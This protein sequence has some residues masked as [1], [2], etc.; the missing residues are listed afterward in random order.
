MNLFDTLDSDVQEIIQRYLFPVRFPKGQ[1]LM[2]EGDAGDGCY[3]IDSG[4]VRPARLSVL[5]RESR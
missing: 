3:L 4:V 1:C 5:S 2:Q